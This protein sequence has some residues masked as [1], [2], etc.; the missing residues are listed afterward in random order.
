MISNQ[1][2]DIKLSDCF[3]LILLIKNNPDLINYIYNINFIEKI[4]IFKNQINILTQLIFSKLILVL[5]NNYKNSEY[6]NY[7][8]EKT[9]NKIEDSN[10][11]E[12]HKN[13]SILKNFGL[14]YSFS[15]IININI[16]RLYIEI[17]FGLIK[18]NKFDNYNEALSII[19]QLDLEN[20]CITKAMMDEFPR[21]FNYDFYYIKLYMTLKI[22]DLNNEKKINFYYF[23]LKY[24][25]KNSF[26]IYNIPLLLLTRNVLIKIIKKEEYLIKLI[27]LNFNDTDTKKRMEYVLKKLLD[28][29]YYF[30][31]YFNIIIDKLTTLKYYFS[32]LQKNEQINEIKE[33]IE[34]KEKYYEKY[35]KDYEKAK[36]MIYKL[37]KYI[38]EK[39]Y[40]EIFDD[41][42]NSYLNHIDSFILNY[43]NYNYYIGFLLHNIL[44]KSTFELFRKQ[45]L[46]EYKIT[47]INDIIFDSN[48]INYNKLNE[49]ENNNIVIRKD[50]V[51]YTSISSFLNF[52]KQLKT[53]IIENYDYLKDINIILEFN[54][55]MVSNDRYK[56]NISCI[57]STPQYP[58]LSFK[59]ENILIDYTNTK[60][61]GFQFF[62][63][64]IKKNLNYFYST[65][66]ITDIKDQQKNIQYQDKKTIIELE[67]EPISIFNKNGFIL[68]GENYHLIIYNENNIE[69]INYKFNDIITS[70]ILLNS[71]Q[72]I[73]IIAH[74]SNTIYKFE[75]NPKN[76]VE[77]N[78]K[79]IEMSCIFLL[80]LD[81]NNYIICNEQNVKLY[82]DTDLFDKKIINNKNNENIIIESSFQRGIV[83]NKE[84]K[85][86]LLHDKYKFLIYD[87]SKKQNINIL[88]HE[89][90]LKNSVINVILDIYLSISKAEGNTFNGILII[91]RGNYKEEFINTDE[92]QIS[93]FCPIVINE[94]NAFLVAGGCENNKGKIIIYQ[95]INKNNESK[96]KYIQQF[97]YDSTIINIT[98][99]NEKQTLFILCSNKKVYL[100]DEINFI[101]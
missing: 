34:K 97:E 61:Q 56:Y 18:T 4:N 63:E 62:M 30:F 10:K 12:I 17:I 85:I 22:D 96:L 75:I 25:L 44:E 90:L 64:N 88:E 74:S 40:G 57:Y 8:S 13:I 14:T 81:E 60:T 98:F 78:V 83:I 94:N 79:P 26:F 52:L 70:F 59:D 6:Y 20:I 73:K 92:V 35:L 47:N 50:K 24:I 71:K 89:Y 32:F 28:N 99:Q 1:N 55:E 53:R 11:M 46:Y 65:K 49:I 38:L 72:N 7:N 39:Q 67:E 91:N 80:Q 3:F 19:E 48:E 5:T 82:N 45:N 31:K 66:I 101:S 95:V 29:D 77:F 43:Y 15:D 51:L 100:N 21:V 16:D 37:V 9:I 69:I 36:Q 33:I 41:C 93:C 87:V 76:D 42:L 68:I 2:D 23:L 84:K 27:S 54:K 58:K 86:I